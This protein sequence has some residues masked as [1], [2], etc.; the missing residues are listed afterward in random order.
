MGKIELVT[1]RIKSVGFLILTNFTRSLQIST[2]TTI[3][4]AIP[5]QKL[6]SHSFYLPAI[7]TL[8]LCLD[9]PARFSWPAAIAPDPTTLTS[10]TLRHVR[11]SAL[12][13]ILSC[14]K[15][16][17]KLDWQF[18]YSERNIATRQKA[19]PPQ[20]ADLDVLIDALTP[21]QDTLKDLTVGADAIQAGLD[22]ESSIEVRGSLKRLVE[23]DKVERLQVPLPFL[24]GRLIPNNRLCVSEQNPKNLRTLAINEG[25]RDFGEDD[26]DNEISLN[27]LDWLYEGLGSTPFIEQLDLGLV[28]GHGEGGFC[29]ELKRL[30]GKE[31]V[32]IKVTWHG[33]PQGAEPNITSTTQ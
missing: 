12:K 30:L 29:C 21:V 13:G 31:R 2:G 22:Y 18:L 25:L 32:P 6:C 23:F 8:D 1:R 33:K 27:L 26:W 11:E 17:I 19:P 4:I 15:R 10:L 3:A 28:T 20:I 24:A 14:T 7:Q 16:L 9:N 5:T